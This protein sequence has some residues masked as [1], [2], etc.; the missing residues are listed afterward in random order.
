MK[1]QST[2]VTP[3][4]TPHSKTEKSQ[5]TTQPEKNSTRI[6][7]DQNDV[8]QPPTDEKMKKW[9]ISLAG[10][11]M[12]KSGDHS[13][14]IGLRTEREI[15]VAGNENSRF[16]F[17]A[18]GG[19]DLKLGKTTF[20]HAIGLGVKGSVKLADDVNAYL[21][22]SATANI[23]VI[24]GDL[25]AGVGL[26]EAAG[27][28]YKQFFAEAFA[29]QTTNY[30]TQGLAVGARFTFGDKDKADSGED[31][32]KDWN[33]SVSGGHLERSGEHSAFAGVRAEREVTFV[34]NEE[35]RFKLAAT[36]A[37]ELKLGKSTFNQSI[38]IGVKASVKLAEDVN[39]YLGVGGTA[40]VGAIHGDLTAGVGL[41]EAAGVTYK[42]FFAEAFAEQATNYS[43]QGLAVGAK[44][45]F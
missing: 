13:G 17:S 39:A 23:G 33:I 38:N 37:N 2:Q 32:A 22:G 4:V 30:S 11:H 26:R 9:S 12:E 34:G 21:S 29:E 1:I 41:R 25:T 15:T 36:G 24:Q 7:G 27:V 42:K 45:K 10:G 44:F 35:S 28:E 31:K 40:N 8:S 5:S 20:H 19:H 16:K 18:I 14:F 43:T 3:Q 6:S